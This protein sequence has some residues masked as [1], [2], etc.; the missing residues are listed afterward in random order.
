MK[1]QTLLVFL[2]LVILPLVLAANALVIGSPIIGIV[3]SLLFLCLASWVTSELL[4]YREDKVFRMTFGFVTILMFLALIGNVLIVIASFTE[5]VSLIAVVVSSVILGL[6]FVRHRKGYFPTAPS[7]SDKGPVKKAVG[8]P[9]MLLIL[10]L[11]WVFAAFRLLWI[12]RTDEGGASVWMTIPNSFLPLFLLVSFSLL[13]V[14][15][16]TRLSNSLKLGLVCLYSFLVHSLFLLVWYPGR[17]GDPWAQLGEARY[18]S[19]TGMPYAYDWMIQQRLIPQLALRAQQALTVFFGR[20]F[21][22]DLYWVH[23]VL[24]PLL[25]SILVPL[26]A[27]IIADRLSVEKSRKFPILA[28]VAT[29]LFPSLILWGTVSVPNSLGFIFFFVSVALL[30]TW[31]NHGDK[32]MWLLSSLASITSFLAHPQPGLFAFFLLFWVTVTHKTTRKIWSVI[33]YVPLFLVYPLSLLYRQASF[34]LGGLSILDNFLSFQSEISTIL[35]VFGVVGLILGVKNHFVRTK[36]ALMLFI[37]YLTLLSEYY[38]T[39]FGMTNLPFGAERIL[40]MANFMLVPF[41]AL[42]FIIIVRIFGKVASKSTG[43]LSLS[44]PLKGFKMGLGRSR[45][46]FL[47]IC[48][49]LSLQATS[50]LYQAYPQNELVK[51]QPSGYELEAIKY[52]NSDAKGSRYVVL[53]DTTFAGLAIG[54]LGADYSFGTYAQPEWSY[55]TMVLYVDMTTQPSLSYMQQ[56][57]DFAGA[58]VS[59]FV[60]SV[61]NPDFEEVVERTSEVLPVNRVFGEGKLYVFKYPLSV[62]EELGSSVKVVFDDGSKTESVPTWLTYMVESEITASLNLSGHVSYNVTEYPPHWTFLNLTVNNESKHFDESSNIDTFIYVKGLEPSDVVE[63]EWLFNSNYPRVGWKE[64]SF[65]RE[66]HPHPQYLGIPGKP[67]VIA[68]D[69][70]VLSISHSFEPRAIWYYYH[71]TSVGV[72]TNDYPYLII[73]W[74]S[75]LPTAVAYVYFEDE[76]AQEIVSFGSQ[77]VDWGSTVVKL[78]SDAVVSMVM[79]GLSNAVNQQLSGVGTLEVDFI[80]ICGKAT[81]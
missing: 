73:R 8:G 13:V 58:K 15:V 48:L 37:I 21:F 61:R 69:G 1:K 55:P 76:S 7:K 72:S 35:L 57:L 66:W 24:I 18:I 40:T 64:D 30:I 68:N 59:Y 29:L 20:M 10:F 49:F 60:V 9:V 19:S 71:V 79:V 23:I 75:N 53:G 38:L 6:A 17:Y 63:V 81:Q 33:I 54:Y 39:E 34:S 36:S 31:I 78:K 4:F 27:Y 51:V 52:I 44:V 22:V 12:S 25:W 2:I 50:A 3:S 80:L 41:V 74:R 56:A 45:V 77:S 42:G 16:F 67:P 26:I 32:R 5:V 47:V 65:K 11:V 14:L 62:V 70:N 46:G 43:N 28:A